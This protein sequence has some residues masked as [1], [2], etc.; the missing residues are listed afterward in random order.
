MDDIFVASLMSTDVQTVRPDTL[1]E[2]A[3]RQM[4]EANI[5]SLV[6]VDDDGRLE[7]ILTST[8]FVEIVQKSQPKAQTT[9]ERYMSTDVQTATAQESIRDVADRMLQHGFHHMPVVDDDRT[10]IGM[11]ST[12]DL[13]GYVS[14]LEPTPET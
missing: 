13:T 11:L 2:D 14:T 4:L 6:V 1:V 8:D 7:G 5:G 10:V 9:V 12:S 3:A